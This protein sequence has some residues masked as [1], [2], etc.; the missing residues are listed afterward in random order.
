MKECKKPEQLHAQLHTLPTEVSEN[1]TG[2][3]VHRKLAA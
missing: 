1:A 3:K 2:R